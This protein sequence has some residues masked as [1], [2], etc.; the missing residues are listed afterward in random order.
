MLFLKTIKTELTG[1]T[2]TINVVREHT[3]KTELLSSST[4]IRVIRSFGGK[5]KQFC[6]FVSITT[7]LVK[8]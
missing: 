6:N 3:A 1:T 7:S 8:D 5:D 2:Q 4:S